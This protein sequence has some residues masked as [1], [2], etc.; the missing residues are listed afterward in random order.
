MLIHRMVTR[1]TAGAMMLL[2][3]NKCIGL[4][5]LHVVVSKGDKIIRISNR[6]VMKRIHS[7]ASIFI[8]Y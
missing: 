8:D 3:N 1:A 4:L 7:I 6:V 2:F 5:G